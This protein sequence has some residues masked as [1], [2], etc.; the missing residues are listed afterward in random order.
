MI[1]CAP[2][3]QRGLDLQAAEISHAGMLMSGSIK[4]SAQK[5]CNSSVSGHGL[6][7]LQR[8]CHSTGNFHLADQFCSPA[9]PHFHPDAW[10]LLCF[11]L[12]QDEELC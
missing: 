10:R 3:T 6:G 5:S 7:G 9:D 12:L 2:T 11:K 1:S 4:D 8:L